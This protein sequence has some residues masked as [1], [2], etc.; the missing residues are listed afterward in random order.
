M[1]YIKKLSGNLCYLSPINLED[2]QLYTQWLN[3]PEVTRFLNLNTLNISYSSEQEALAGMA[4]THNYAVVDISTDR[5]IGNCGLVDWN[6]IHGTA[7]A[8][9]FIGEKSFWGKGYGAE[10]LYLLSEYAFRVLNIKSML[11][12]VFS[13]NE[14]AI[15]C[16]EKVGYKQIGRWRNALEYGSERF[17]EIFMDCIPSE[18]IQPWE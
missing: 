14:R 6:Q 18:L 7:E 17:D 8:G 11:L 1:R 10:T 3:D 15:S 9:L 13:T 5:L 2:Y 16:Y 12:K 4:K